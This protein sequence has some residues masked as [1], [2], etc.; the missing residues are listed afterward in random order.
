MLLLISNLFKLAL[1]TILVILRQ[2]ILGSV[3][4]LAVCRSM[5]VDD[6]LAAPKLL[7]VCS[8]LFE[9]IPNRLHNSDVVLCVLFNPTTTTTT[10]VFPRAFDLEQSRHDL[11]L[12]LTISSLSTAVISHS[13]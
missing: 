8:N 5:A 7:K 6:S 4:G 9:C 3:Y 13:T 11:T 12:R 2:P 10:N 1:Q